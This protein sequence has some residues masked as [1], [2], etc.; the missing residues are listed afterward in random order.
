MP[1][2]ANRGCG[3]LLCGIQGTVR[4]GEIASWLRD[5]ADI[6]DFPHWVAIDDIDMRDELDPH[7]V[8]TNKRIGLTQKDADHAIWK[9]N[10]P[11]PCAC[12]LCCLD[13]RESMVIPSERMSE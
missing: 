1:S 4:P 10:S 8:K 6:V 5:N 7:M 12:D 13:T 9:L 3:L 11:E 2:Q